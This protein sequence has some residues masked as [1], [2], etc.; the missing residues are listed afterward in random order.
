MTTTMQA[1]P[2]HRLLATT[3]FLCLCAQAQAA[4]GSLFADGERVLFLG[5]SIT[6]AGGWHSQI[7]LFYATRFLDRRITWLNAGISGDTS[8]GAVQR[9]QWDVLAR[10]P[11]T[12]VIMLGMNDA[13]RDDLPGE[14]GM[15]EVGSDE[16]V[17]EF[18][19][20]MRALVEKLRANGVNVILCTPSPYDVTVKVAAASHAA[21]NDALTRMAAICRELA[22]EFDLPM[23]DFNGPMNAIG[24]DYQKT[25]P[26]FTL[27][28]GDRVHPGALG[29]TLMAHLFLEAQ[30]LPGLI[31]DIVVDAERGEV[32]RMEN[33]TARELQVDAGIISFT[34]A[35]NALPMPFDTA[36][37]Q[38]LR[39]SVENEL[40]KAMAAMAE[41]WRAHVSPG[42]DAVPW[43][44][45]L[46]RQMLTVTGLPEGEYE[47]LID[48]QPVGR[49][50]HDDLAIGVNLSG[51][52]AT[53]QYQQAEK[54]A[55]AHGKRHGAAG[56]VPRMIA[57]TRHFTLDPA[58]IDESDQAAVKN[59]LEKLLNDPNANDNYD[60]GGYAQAMAKRY[61]ENKPKEGEIAAAIAAADD[62]VHQLNQPAPHRYLLRPVAH[63]LALEARQAAFAARRN[64]EN[65]QALATEFLGLLVLDGPGLLRTNL[66][67]RPGLQKVAELAN[68]D[69][70]VEALEAW[71]DYFFDKLR[72][73][74]AHGLPYDLFDPY[75]GLIRMDQKDQVMAQA[76]RLLQGQ[77]AD[78]T[79]PMPPGSVWLPR[80]K[81]GPYGARNPWAPETFQPLAVAYLLTGQR[82]YL[83]KWIEYLDDWAMH[84]IH[85]DAIRPTD[86]SDSDH[87]GPGT[88]ITVYRTLAAIARLQPADTIDFPADSLARVLGKLVR[89]AMPPSLVYHDTNPQNWTPGGSGWQMTAAMLMDEFRAAEYFFH[90]ARHRH[91]NYGTIQN[92]PDGGETE[93][94]LWYNAH[95]FDGAKAALD[96]VDSRRNINVWHRTFWENPVYA[97]EWEH[98]QRGKITERA[99][100]FLQMLTPQSQY[101]I[102]N[103]SDQRTLPDW[104]S[105]A[106]VNYAILDGAPDLAVLLNA[107]R[108]NTAAGLPDFTM[109]AFPYSGSW[110]M[111]TGW[112]RDAGYAHF[113]SS[114]HPTSG[115]GMRGLKC[116]NG[117]WLSHAG[118]DLLTS[119][120]FGTYSYDRSPLRVDGKGQFFM[121][122]IGNPGFSKNHKGFGVALIDPSPAA[123]RSH[124]SEHFDFAEGVY[125]GP[126]GDFVDDHHDDKDYRPGFLAERAREVIA[127][128]THHR[129]VFQVKQPGLWIVVD[130]LRSSQPRE[131][132]LDWRLPVKHLR[133]FNEERH[134]R[135]AGKTFTPE[136]IVIDEPQQAIATAA[137]DMPNLTIRHFGPSMRFDTE[138]EEGENI[139]RN[140][141]I[142]YKI[143]DFW[144]VGGSWQSEGDDRVIS[145]IEVVPEGA[146]SQ[147]TEVIGTEGGFSATLVDGIPLSFTA[148]DTESKLAL[149]D[150]GLVIADESYEY[151]G[152]VPRPSTLAPRTSR[153]AKLPIWHPIAPVRIE[154]ERNIIAGAEPVTISCATADVE[155]RYT[156]DGSEPTPLSTLYTSPF[157]LTASVT[158]KARAFRPGLGQTPAT[159]AGTHATPTR[160]ARF[161]HAEPLEPVAPLDAQRY[162]PG[163]TA[164]YFEGDWKDLAFFP[165]T[166]KPLRSMNVRHLF[167]RCQPDPEKVFGWTYTGFLAIPEDGVYTFHAPE[168]MT[169]SP[170]EPGYNLRLFAG[171]ELMFNNRPSGRLNEWYPATTRHAY[172]TW[173]IALK[174]GLHPFEV[175]YVD[176]R[177]DAAE[178]LNHPGMRLNTL[179]NGAVPE[180]LMSGPEM[181]PQAI[182]AAWMR[183]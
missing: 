70:P 147:I 42:W 80:P 71:R 55:A 36:A 174:K 173:S 79:D 104:K 24:A 144:R 39:L 137:P 116:N 90:R 32:I 82:D 127:G 124:A 44:D 23:V 175:R 97:A 68:A 72:N 109:S 29:N 108:G 9:L 99:R 54:V 47:L 168:E 7:A 176:Y 48:E 120:D 121:A 93:H 62:D 65:V 88:M 6:R 155:I 91:E 57:F 60:L 69:Q 115:H 61:L 142:R 125:A 45:R 161:E 128:V 25:N 12:V 151:Q 112:G 15:G 117:F 16:R 129:Q 153:L 178:R 156:L 119:G 18:A 1:R 22:A 140:Y 162:Q 49:W 154:P 149:G 111:R 30:G 75:K 21:A 171:R 158:V 118:H 43:R 63:P 165:D 67:R 172:G 135:F 138:R 46:H 19:K 4:A 123:W 77:F 102:G 105:T 2:V 100:Y 89:V 110:I 58:G 106:M 141:T 183:Q 130:R 114:P 11:D 133:E 81:E 56:W 164:A 152:T 95:Y 5:D 134:V 74:A 66:R 143:Y 98:M 84:G 92:L 33:A 181:E 157:T 86:I 78:D 103:R 64:P 107:L 76:D 37:R 50:W 94:A 159:L 8:G 139:A 31:S 179:W 27:I 17:A 10:E 146:A 34:L 131:Y 96:L 148:D 53:P 145:L 26:N 73:P 169:T 122:G 41:P 87:R 182:P 101:P 170:Q 163:L 126:Y 136:T 59:C 132:T 113:F 166:V 160:V 150:R 3:I 20:N 14:L 52:R 83:D 28:G 167:D 35:E 38:A 177:A 13:A 40:L 85:E 180:I 51:V